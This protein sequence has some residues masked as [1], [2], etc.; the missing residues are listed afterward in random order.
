MPAWSRRCPA[1][2]AGQGRIG[3]PPITARSS[4]GPE[5]ARERA[6]PAVPVQPS[7]ST[8]RSPVLPRCIA[9]RRRVEGCHRW[10]GVHVCGASALL[11]G[12]ARRPRSRCARGRA[13]AA[14]SSSA[15]RRAPGPGT[16]CTPAPRRRRHRCSSRRT[17]GARRTRPG[18]GPPPHRNGR[19]RSCRCRGRAWV[20]P[21]DV[22]ARRDGPRPERIQPDVLK[23]PSPSS[24]I[25][26]PATWSARLR[27]RSSCSRPAH[28]G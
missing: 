2:P 16:G 20:L 18:R 8:V 24:S 11:K 21:D 28:R 26:K 14:S 3:R 9:R 13:Q 15:L 12:P 23:E 1:Q 19:S 10:P 22:A 7:A 4:T 17:R 6:S 25:R 5:D 27:P